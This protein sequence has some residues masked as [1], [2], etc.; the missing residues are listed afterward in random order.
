MRLKAIIAASMSEAFLK[1][2]EELGDEAVIVQTEELPDGMFRLTAAIEE[3]T[4]DYE[5]KIRTEKAQEFNDKRIRESLDYHGVIDVV[6]NKILSQI[7]QL[8]QKEGLDKEEKLLEESLGRI[9]QFKNLQHDGNKIKLFMGVPGSGK[10]TAIAKY[11]AK[12]KFDNYSS[13]IISTD[14]VRAGANSQLKAYADI[15]GVPFL[16]VKEAEELEAIILEKEKQY[17]YILIDTPGINPFIE[18]EVKR[19]R[20]L[21]EKVVADKILTMDAG[22]NSYEAV[23]IADIFCSVGATFILPTRMDLTR[24]IGAILSVAG[25]T[26]LIFCAASVSAKIAKG[27]AEVDSPSLSRIILT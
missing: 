19:L 26:G 10:S 3:E 7:R 18:A 20:N 15:L 17:D 4:R 12:G 8:Y 2:H 1:V 25:C 9:Y 24:R 5:E 11:A 22:K 21:T 14:N 16:Y 27:M 23:E 13:C 6:K